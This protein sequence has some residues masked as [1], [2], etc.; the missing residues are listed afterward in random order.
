M[1]LLFVVAEGENE[2]AV[3][4]TTLGQFA[5][6]PNLNPIVR[7]NDTAHKRSVTLFDLNDHPLCVKEGPKISFLF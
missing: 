5:E 1:H 2:R 4:R 3:V 6:K 7:L